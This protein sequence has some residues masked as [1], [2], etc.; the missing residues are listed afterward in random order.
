[1]KLYYAAVEDV[2]GYDLRVVANSP[3]ECKNA[4]IQEYKRKF[5][6]FEE[7]G[8]EDADDWLVIIA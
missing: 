2:Y 6:S 5:G 1:M 8:F 7:N 4:L 3:E